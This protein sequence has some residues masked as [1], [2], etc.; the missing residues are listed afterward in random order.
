MLKRIIDKAEI[1]VLGPP[2]LCLACSE[3]ATY[4]VH[5]RSHEIK[6]PACKSCATSAKEHGYKITKGL[7]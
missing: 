6:M 1:K 7:P 2:V 5:G 3:R 4:T